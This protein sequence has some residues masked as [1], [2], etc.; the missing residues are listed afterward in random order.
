[1]RKIL[2]GISLVLLVVFS[3]VDTS[4]ASHPLI[5][6]DA[7]TIGKGSVQIELNYEYAHEKNEDVREDEHE[8]ETVLTY[9]LIDQLD[10]VLALPF[11]FTRADE[12]GFRDRE[13]GI[14]DMS[15]EVKWRFYECNGLSLALKP[16]V[17]IPTGDDDRGLGTGRVGAGAFFIATQEWEPWAFHFNL[18]YLRN[19]NKVGERKDLYHVSLATEWEVAKWVKL[20]GNVGAEANTDRGSDTPAAFILGG[21]IFP[22]AEWLD[23]DIGVKGGLTRPEADYSL[24]AG[25]CFHF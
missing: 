1:M 19:E 3:T 9:G 5:T 18:G 13:E 8:I 11:L 16:G 2:A 22:V 25:M 17:T 6:D 15:F 4:R 14:G 12:D 10:L 24:L 20:V 7:G 23:L 21:L